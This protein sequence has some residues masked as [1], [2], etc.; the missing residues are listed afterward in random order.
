MKGNYLLREASPLFD[1]PLP[2]IPSKEKRIMVPES[3]DS[4]S[5][6]LAIMDRGRDFREG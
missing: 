3:V 1:S 4:P 2:S 6:F 5:G